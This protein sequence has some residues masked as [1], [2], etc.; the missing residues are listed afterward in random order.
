MLAVIAACFA[1]NYAA[2]FDKKMDQN[3]DN[4]YYLLLARSLSQGKGYVT[5]IGLAPEPHTHFPPGYPAFLSLFLRTFPE[6]IVALKVINGLLLLAAL[7]LLFRIVRKTAGKQGLWIAFSS[8]L[9]CCFHPIL[10]RWATILM[11]EMLFIVISLGMI[12][13]YVELDMEKVRQKD[14]RHILRLVALCLLTV[15]LY[16]V[17]TMGLA[18]ILAMSLSFL[19][20]GMKYFFSRKKESRHWGMPLLAAFLILFSCGIAWEAWSLRNQRIA[21]GTKSDYVGAFSAQ[22]AEE[23]ADNPLAFRLQRI[24]KN[25]N[26]FVPHYIPKALLMPKQADYNTISLEKDQQW[27]LGILVIVLML[28][29]M[30]FIKKLALLGLLYFMATFGVLLLYPP[31]LAD[32]RYFIPLIPLMLAFL[33]SGVCQVVLW[34]VHTFFKWDPAWLTPVLSLVIVLLLM[35]AYE[36]GIK[37]Y[38]EKGSAETYGETG[39]SSY[40]TYIDM[41]EK[42]AGYPSDWVFVARKPEI[43]Y[44]HSGYHHAIPMNRY[45]TPKE[46]MLYLVESRA[47]GILLDSL[48]PTTMDYYIPTI[49]AYYELFS[50]LW[51]GTDPEAPGAI[52]S[53]N[54]VISGE[55]V[56][57]MLKKL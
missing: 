47:S 19:L 38:H 30:V 52:V 33:V 46:V 51:K 22:S 48:Y 3:G 56:Y 29:G 35:P 24:G 21:P 28:V 40:Q 57:E 15:A 32:V 10:L 41:C 26:A 50:F 54:P 39:F 25:L 16:Y 23:K 45:D 37:S 11:S 4:Y 49:Q 7:F 2:V 53:F 9:L 42:C 8:C 1:W 12:A 36:K 55:S 20:L 31:L 18:L 6:N 13:L 17:R 14:I 43:F 44:V 27:V 5:D 34:L